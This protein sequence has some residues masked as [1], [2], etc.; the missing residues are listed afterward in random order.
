MNSVLDTKVALVTGG[1][2]GIGAAAIALKLASLG[3]TTTCPKADARWPVCNTPLARSALLA[4]RRS[5]GLS[6]VADWTSGGR[7]RGE[8]PKHFLAG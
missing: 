7:T 2:R 8:D 4:A 5:H 1:G 6:D 3:A